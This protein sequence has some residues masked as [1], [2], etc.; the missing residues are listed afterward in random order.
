MEPTE[1]E[2][3]GGHSHNPEVQEGCVAHGVALWVLGQPG[4]SQ[5]RSWDKLSSGSQI[6]DVLDAS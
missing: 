1:A 3:P 6:K 2:G 4:Q 5:L